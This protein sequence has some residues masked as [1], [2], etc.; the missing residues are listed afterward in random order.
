MNTHEDRVMS[1]RLGGLHSDVHR[2]VLSTVEADH[3]GMRWPHGR[4]EQQLLATRLIEV[5]LMLLGHATRLPDV[6]RASVCLPDVIPGPVHEA[7][8]TTALP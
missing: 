2:F 3:H 6:E 4:N 5:G 7:P 1:A 8:K